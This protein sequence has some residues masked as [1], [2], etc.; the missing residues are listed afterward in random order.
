MADRKGSAV[1]LAEPSQPAPMPDRS[2]PQSQG[3]QLG[4]CHHSMLAIGQ[5]AQGALE[6]AS[7][8]NLTYTASFDG[9]AGHGAE[10]V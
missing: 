7:P 1:E 5:L 10:A 9:L 6:I 2:L 3:F 4:P 8:W